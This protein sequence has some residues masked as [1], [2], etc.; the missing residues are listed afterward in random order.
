M[1]FLVAHIPLPIYEMGCMLNGAKLMKRESIFPFFVIPLVHREI[2]LGHARVARKYETSKEKKLEGI[3]ASNY[4]V[5]I[6][7]EEEMSVSH[8]TYPKGHNEKTSRLLRMIRKRL[9][10]ACFTVDDASFKTSWMTIIIVE[11]AEVLRVE[12]K[13][14][15]KE[16]SLGSTHVTTMPRMKLRR[17]SMGIRD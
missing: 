16:V 2:D 14:T 6:L 10:K 11:E 8:L 1:D 3:L 12:V 17:P 4:W 5:L 15:K 9:R 13:T 7:W